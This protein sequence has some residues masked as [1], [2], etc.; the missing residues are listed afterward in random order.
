MGFCLGIG[1]L[2]LRVFE[3]IPALAVGALTA[4]L[5]AMGLRTVTRNPTWYDTATV[6]ETLIEEH[7]E[8]GRAQWILGTYHMQGGRAAQGMAAYDRA[9][10]ILQMEAKDGMVDQ[11]LVDILVQAEV[12]KKVLEQDWREL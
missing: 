6:M 10:S 9:L 2:G 3:R 7:P 4:A 8:S 1:W 12:Y 5:I 11:N